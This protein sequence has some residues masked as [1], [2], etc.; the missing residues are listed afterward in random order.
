MLKNIQ[1]F[2]DKLKMQDVLVTYEANKL[3]IKASKGAMTE[4]IMTA[5]K[6]KKPA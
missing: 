4:E 3:K 5:L 1:D 2:I 6:E